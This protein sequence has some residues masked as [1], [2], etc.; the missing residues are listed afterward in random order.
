MNPLAKIRELRMQP[1]NRD[2]REATRSVKQQA[3]RKHDGKTRRRAP[4][5]DDLFTCGLCFREVERNHLRQHH[6]IY[7]TP[8]ARDASSNKDR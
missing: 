2:A 1:I 5:L 6:G 4:A 7:R 3:K 8:S